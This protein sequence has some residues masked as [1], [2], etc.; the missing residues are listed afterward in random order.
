MITMQ[1]TTN[2]RYLVY[3]DCALDNYFF[4]EYTER[5]L[6]FFHFF[7]TTVP[8]MATVDHKL[9][10]LAMSSQ[11]TLFFLAEIVLAGEFTD[12]EL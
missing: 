11:I 7:L 5:F 12:L 8:P 4:T 6:V 3:V 9:T 10:C 1:G 2:I